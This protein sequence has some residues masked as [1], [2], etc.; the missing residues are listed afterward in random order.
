MELFIFENAKTRSLNAFRFVPTI[1][2]S[3]EAGNKVDIIDDQHCQVLN[4][5]PLPLVLTSARFSQLS[6]SVPANLR[7]YQ[8]TFDSSLLPAFPLVVEKSV[9]VAADSPFGRSRWLPGLR[10]TSSSSS[11]YLISRGRVSITKYFS[12]C[13]RTSLKSLRGNSAKTSRCLPAAA[14]SRPPAPSNTLRL[15]AG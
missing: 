12:I 8:R 1:V 2:T 4:P 15:G 5:P 9:T 6:K 14:G 3:N 13:L 11:R 7:G 10:A